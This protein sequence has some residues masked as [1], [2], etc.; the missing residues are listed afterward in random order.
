ME[1]RDKIIKAANN[2]DPLE[3]QMT[4]AALIATELEKKGTKVVLVG[5]SAVE[6][7]TAANYLTRDIDFI[8]TRLDGIKEVMTGLGFKNEGGTWY[9]PENPNIVVEFPKGPLDGDWNRIQNVTLPDGTSVNVIGIEDI[10]IDRACAVKYWNDPEEWI[11]Y[12]MVGNFE[13][14]DWEYLNKRSQEM[15]CVDIINKSKEWAKIQRE[16]FLNENL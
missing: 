16:S 8:A 1:A 2:K 9:L 6:F 12:L 10:L 7:Y 13:H 11:N 15:D 14:I 5:G 3:R 4:V